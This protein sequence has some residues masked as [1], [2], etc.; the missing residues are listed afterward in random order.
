MTVLLLA[1]MLAF[2]QETDT[3]S[4][5]PKLPTNKQES[6]DMAWT[7]LQGGLA[8][9]SSDRRAKAAKA[10]GLM[11]NDPK[12]QG[13]A[14]K[15]LKD[16]N[17]D[18]RAAAA[19]ALGAMKARSSIPELKETLKDSQLKVVVAAANSLYDFKD[20]V[21]YD[22]YYAILTGEQKGPGLVQSQMQT[23]R[24]RKQIE[25]LAVETGIGFIPFGGVGYEAYKRL[26]KDD[27]SPV[28]AAAAEKLATDPD[29]KT[30][31]ALG[32]ACSDKQWQVRFAVVEAIAKRGNADLLFSVTPLLY[33]NNDAVRY[34][35][36]ATVIRLTTKPPAPEPE[37]KKKSQ[38]RAKHQ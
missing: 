22:I 31:E 37:A 26:T 36:A 29:P 30:T 6:I 11:E 10:L 38:R 28:R 24:D 1:F 8:E 23:L 19:G 27:A 14:E 12:A 3:S 7:V 21:A 35:S 25:G 2:Q 4:Q 18:V 15:A 13:Y 9:K 17:P 5:T 32:R 16:S 20:P 34:A 33:D